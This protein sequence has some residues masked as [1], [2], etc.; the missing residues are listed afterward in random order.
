M[1]YFKNRFIKALS[2]FLIILTLGS[3]LAS[4]CFYDDESSSEE[5]DQTSADEVMAAVLLIPL[6][7]SNWRLFSGDGNLVWTT[8]N[9]NLATPTTLNSTTPQGGTIMGG[10]TC[11]YVYTAPAASGTPVFSLNSLSQNPELYAGVLADTTGGTPG[12]SSCTTTAPG[13]GWIRCS[14]TTGNESLDMNQVGIQVMAAG[15]TRLVVVYGNTDPRAASVYL[16]S[17]VD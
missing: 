7:F 2:R 17:V 14:R 3:Y 12:V 6:F 15:Q 13:G 16:L 5:Y 9:M 10:D 4:G 8:C 1:S 11:Y